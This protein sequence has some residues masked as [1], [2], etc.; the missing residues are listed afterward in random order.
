MSFYS[1]KNALFVRPHEKLAIFS[2]KSIL[3]SKLP[4]SVLKTLSTCGRKAKTEENS[5]FS[6]KSGYLS[7]DGPLENKM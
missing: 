4:F 3:E 6:K 2:K 1:R 5:P 7:E